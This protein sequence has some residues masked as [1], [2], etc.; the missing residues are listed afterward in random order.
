[1]SK[2]CT[3]Q[4]RIGGMR[5]KLL[6]LQETDIQAQNIG[7]K[8]PENGKNI[9]GMLNYQDFFYVSQI[10]RTELI[11]SYYDDFLAKNFKIKKT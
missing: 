8:K 9:D 10:I 7:A 1:M 6:E 5:I 3:Y 2:K 4:A 11:N